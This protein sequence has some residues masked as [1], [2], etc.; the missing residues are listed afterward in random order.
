M[1]LCE[2]TEYASTLPTKTSDR[3]CTALD[4]C[5]LGVTFETV[6]PTPTSQR[7]CS[8]V[9]KCGAEEY[10]FLRATYKHDV[11]CRAW[12]VCSNDEYQ[13][14]SPTAN[15]DRQCK[16]KKECSLGQNYEIVAPG[17]FNDRICAPVT[18]P[19][20]KRKFETLAP[21][22]KNDRQCQ[23]LRICLGAVKTEPTYTTDRICDDPS[24]T[25]A[26][27]PCYA[28]FDA[29]DCYCSE[30]KLGLDCAWC[31]ADNQC[32]PGHIDTVTGLIDGTSD[33]SAP[34]TCKV[35]TL[36]DLMNGWGANC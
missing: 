8:S 30:T 27:S 10:V 17:E 29:N 36:T 14:S 22:L 6:A 33:T 20:G 15:R 2:A 1:T 13:I 9:S 19:C 26:P 12:T 34:P 18:P 11:E 5:V 32:Y 35:G 7:I 4:E 23:L 24:T 21:T 31:F 25:T 3:K 28:V 16:R